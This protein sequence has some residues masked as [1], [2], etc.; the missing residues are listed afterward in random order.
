MQ[1]LRA[2]WGLR[3]PDRPGSHRHSKPIT[4]AG[5]V[6]Y[7]KLDRS[8]KPRNCRGGQAWD[9]FDKKQDE[10]N[11]GNYPCHPGLNCDVSLCMTCS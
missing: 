4:S 5:A 11:Y 8:G 2:P 9:N 10:S 6:D 7:G 1:H 3:S